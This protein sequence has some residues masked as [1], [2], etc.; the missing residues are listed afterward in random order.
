[1]TTLPSIRLKERT[2]GN[3]KGAID[4]YNRKALVKLSIQEFR[5][6][7]YEFLSQMI[8]R[9]KELPIEIIPK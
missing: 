9:D 7:S 3:M 8:L 4:K 5:R 1:M 6:L 2:L